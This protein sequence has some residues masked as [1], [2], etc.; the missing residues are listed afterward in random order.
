MVIYRVSIFHLS[1]IM[2]IETQ[3]EIILQKLRDAGPDGLSKSKLKIAKNSEQAFQ[4]LLRDREIRNLG[5]KARPRYVLKAYYNPLERAYNEIE[6]ITRMPQK[7]NEL[8]PF[9]LTT[10]RNKLPS[11]CI[12]EKAD[13]AIEILI[14][15]K[16]LLK[17]KIGRGTYFLH[18]SSIEPYV[19]SEAFSGLQPE[20]R[21]FEE[22]INH[23][24]VLT[25][26]EKI[27]RQKGFSNIEIYELQRDLGV[28]MEYLKSFLLEESRAGRAVFSLGDWSLSSGE[29]RSGAV[30]LDGRPY[31]LIRFL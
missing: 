31:L 17:I 23:N 21:V 16:K 28:P 9:T 6:C 7:Q 3:K 13:E 12:R 4:E 22:E 2:G 11:G 1:L 18:V 5:S 30:Y 25:S 29:T 14:Q 15:E 10:I 26:Y 24:K 8:I 20:S 19:L 27:K